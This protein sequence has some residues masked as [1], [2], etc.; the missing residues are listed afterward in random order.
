MKILIV[1]DEPV[2]AQRISRHVSTYFEHSSCRV[3]W[4]EDIDDAL[5]YLSD[6]QIDLL[7]LD[8]NLHGEDGFEV[9]KTLSAESFHTII[10]SACSD[11]AINAFEY[12]V[13]DFVAKPFSKERLFKA[14][15]RY[16]QKYVGHTQ[17]KKLAIKSAGL[18]SYIEISEIQFIQ[19][20]G[21]Y[22]QIHLLDEQKL[23]DKNLDKLSQLL[24]EQFVRVHRSFIVNLNF[25][26]SLKVAGGGQYHL[27]MQN[28]EA[29]PVS[30]AKYADVK[31]RLV[32]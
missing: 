17:L 11:K 12:G 16:Q 10:I 28:G 6:N 27:D 22:S 30:R 23:H 7:L 15:A 4:V 24:S 2:I 21:H 19:A 8:L 20:D 13:L 26:K 5:D 18:L 32:K 25:V 14:L 3:K 9:L 31:A 29:V 1:E